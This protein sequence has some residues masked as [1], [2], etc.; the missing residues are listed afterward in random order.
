MNFNYMKEMLLSDLLC[1]YH[2]TN[3]S[4]YLKEIKNRMLFCGYTNDEITEFIQF[5]NDILKRKKEKNNKKII[6][7]Q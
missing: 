4:K 7:K 6:E 1:L 2:S 3:E 5:E